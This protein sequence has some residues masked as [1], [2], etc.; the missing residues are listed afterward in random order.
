VSAGRTGGG[1]VLLVP[2]TFIAF[3]DN[4]AQFPILSPFAVSLGA[5]PVLAGAILAA[6]SATNLVGNLAVGPVLDRWAPLRLLPPALLLTAVV[7]VLFAHAGTP[8]QLLL[9]RAAHG[10]TAAAIVPAIFV[11]AS[12][13]RAG[14]GQFSRMS[15]LGAGIGVAAL[16]APPAAGVLAAQA[17]TA[18]VYRVLAALALAGAG[19]SVLALSRAPASPPPAAGPVPPD[20]AP[21]ASR[22]RGGR[23]LV[24]PGALL[25]S[26]GALALVAMMASV[27]LLLPL[28]FG[29]AGV[30]S[31]ARAAGLRL[32]LFALAACAVMVGGARLRRD[33]RGRHAL[34]LAGAGLGIL[35]AGAAALAAGGA[36][37]GTTALIAMGAGYG[38]AFPG[39]SAAVSSRTAESLRGRAFGAF[40]ACFSAGAI[41]GPL[42]AGTAAGRAGLGAGYVP[43]ILVAVAIGAACVAE[44]LRAFGAARRVVPAVD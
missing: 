28:Q 22:L 39:L 33:A 34:L 9:L 6:Y 17:G 10:L 21:R 2:I 4:F 25:P 3:A 42:L 13:T 44:P 29:E 30:A 35:A 16:V 15:R 38:L 19:L 8:G 37:A 14:P 36:E 26:F 27:A 1:L 23:P 7:L 24:P 43:A 12:R 20:A 41:L 40:H 5:G 11:H 32:G 31:P 18:G